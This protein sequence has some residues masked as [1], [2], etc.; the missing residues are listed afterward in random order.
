MNK[1]VTTSAGKFLQ[2]EVEKF[3]SLLRDF[4]GI[5]TPGSEAAH[6]QCLE[7][8]VANGDGL[9]QTCLAV[10][11][12][13]EDTQLLREMQQRF[14]ESLSPWICQSWFMTR[15]LE[16]PKGYPGD[17]ILLNGIYENV[18]KSKG[19]GGYLDLYFLGT[20]LACAV[21]SRMEATRKFLSAEIA[22]RAGQPVRVLNVACGSC[23]EFFVGLEY[24]TRDDVK[25]TLVDSD[26]DAL[27]HVRTRVAATPSFKPEME[28]V[29]YNALR[30][31]SSRRNLKMFGS[32]DIIYSIGL[33]D[34]LSDKHLV[35]LLR[36]LRESLS[37]GG[38]LFVAFKDEMGYNK[39][40]YQW[41]VDW[42]FFQRSE[43]D[44]KRILMDAGFTA[45]QV[46]SSRDETGIIMNF[47]CRLPA[48]GQV[49]RFD[50]ASR[51]TPTEQRTPALDPK[52]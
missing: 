14:R 45:D 38:V 5:V 43:S 9:F 40:E 33:L 39:A 28:Y 24:P 12:A 21:R 1:L 15:A 52:D 17:Y 42:F 3:S 27:N 32:S 47:A 50:Q 19:L 36:G 6:D 18:P 2:E 23:R 51:A 8:I 29:Q 4:D 35:P 44:C 25:I 41:L 20:T 11:A 22:A 46:E 48:A 37:P 30:M 34:Y 16:K 7:T 26:Q 31:Q 13:I 10:E 49:L